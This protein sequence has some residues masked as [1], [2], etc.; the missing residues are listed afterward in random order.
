M[1]NSETPPS[2]TIQSVVKAANVMEALADAGKPLSLSQIA[3]AVDMGL[4]TAYRFLRTLEFLEWVE[5]VPD[6]KQYRI[7]PR[8]VRLAHSFFDTSDLWS[9]AHQHLIQARREYNETFNLAV[10]DGTEILYIDRVK[11][12][13]I[14]DINLEIGSKLPAFC[15]SM[16]RV[17]LASLPRAKAHRLLERSVRTPFTRHTVTDTTLLMK[18]LDDVRSQGYAVNRGEMAPELISVAAPVRN[19][20]RQVVAALN[21]A[22]DAGHYEPPEVET[23]LIPAVISV[24]ERISKSLG[25]HR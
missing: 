19:H 18:I 24:A 14:L 25:F 6:L 3:E 22:V 4:P 12:K 16:G 11:T 1:R 15:T 7:A 2:N 13:K 8:I 9:F 23:K 5:R 17:L 20:D 10:L 21:L